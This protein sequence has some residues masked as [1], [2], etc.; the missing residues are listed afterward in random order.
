MLLNKIERVKCTIKGEK[1]D[2]IPYSLWTHFPEVDL[3][4]RK[5]AQATFEFY[6]KLDL[7]F[8]KNMS[9]GMFSI[10]DWGCTCDFSEIASGGV[11]KVT[12]YAIETPNDWNRLGLL[13]VS[14][15]ALGRELKSLEHLLSLIKGEAPV[16]VTVFSP[17]TTAQKLSGSKFFE[18]L[19]TDPDKIKAGLEVI[20][21]STIQFA[22]RALEMGCAGVYFASQLST[23][24]SL[25]ESEYAEFGVPYDMKVLSAIQ[26]LSWFNVMHIHGNNIMFNLL[27][28]YPVQGISWHVWETAPSVQ[29]FLDADTNKCIVGGLQRFHITDNLRTE[30]AE[31]VANMV[32][33]TGG[34][35]LF[36]APGLCHSRTIRLGYP[37]IY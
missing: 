2:R 12:K 15:G 8:I 28:E 32:K 29:Q 26:K 17:L 35:R 9:N 7:D 31:E 4:A 10:E 3:D 6:R 23:Y 30:L 27:K 14:L 24:D 1:T 36:L 37:V 20:A 19:K 25:S 21:A 5:L 34:R 18:H 16:L 22:A 33:L 13:D 11:A